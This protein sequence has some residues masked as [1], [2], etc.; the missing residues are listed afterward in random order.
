M[1]RERLNTGNCRKYGIAFG[2]AVL[3]PAN[4]IAVIRLFFSMISSFQKPFIV[5]NFSESTLMS[6]YSDW[7]LCAVLI[8]GFDEQSFEG[9]VVEAC[10][11]V[12]DLGSITLGDAERRFPIQPKLEDSDSVFPCP[13]VLFKTW[14]HCRGGIQA[15]GRA[16]IA[17]DSSCVRVHRL[18]P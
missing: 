2:E 12:S 6:R 8:G 4:I 14:G 5:I 10:K 1:N 3:K 9:I 13:V 18:T 16:Y 15:G 17:A 11:I 7:A